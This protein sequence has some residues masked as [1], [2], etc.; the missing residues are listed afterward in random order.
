[1]YSINN[2]VVVKAILS[3]L[4]LLRSNMMRIDGCP[5]DCFLELLLYITMAVIATDVGWM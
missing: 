1:V 4:Q 2:S 3:D 5:F